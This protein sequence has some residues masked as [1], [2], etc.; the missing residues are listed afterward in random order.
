M[1]RSK[2]ANSQLQEGF[3]SKNSWDSQSVDKSQKDAPG[4][5][6]EIINL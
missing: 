5:E 3:V 1:I 4:I 6:K 2:S